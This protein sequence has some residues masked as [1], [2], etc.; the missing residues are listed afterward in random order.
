MPYLSKSGDKASSWVDSLSNEP[1]LPIPI[2]ETVLDPPPDARD[3]PGDDESPST[4]GEIRLHI[5]RRKNK[6]DKERGERGGTW[7][8]ST[9]CRHQQGGRPTH[10]SR[11][12]VEISRIARLLKKEDIRLGHSFNRTAVACLASSRCKAVRTDHRTSCRSS[13]GAVSHWTRV[14]NEQ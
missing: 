4:D 2:A 6:R 10:T 12:L 1:P 3:G 5:A 8:P 7:R 14:L 13:D 9:F 11:T